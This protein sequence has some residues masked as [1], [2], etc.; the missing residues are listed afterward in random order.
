MNKT[1]L[2]QEWDERIANYKASGLSARE[3]CNLHEMKI[4]QLHYWLRKDKTTKEKQALAS[5]STKWLPLSLIQE[6]PSDMLIVKVG[7]AKIEITPDFNPELLLKVVQTLKQ[8][9]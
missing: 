7:A 9:C 2:E 5:A 6:N 1:P 3:W 8:L 4:H